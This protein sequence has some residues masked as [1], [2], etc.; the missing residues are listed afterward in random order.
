MSIKERKQLNALAHCTAQE[1]CDSGL[2]SR[3]GG[4]CFTGTNEE[5]DPN[6][7]IFPF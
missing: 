3:S 2:D 1:L 7:V 6:S 4:R 5:N